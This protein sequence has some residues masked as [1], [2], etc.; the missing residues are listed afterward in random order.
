MGL[1][2][3]FKKTKKIESGYGPKSK[4]KVEINGI[5]IHITDYDGMKN[6]IEL[7]RIQQISL[8][9]ND[10]S[11]WGTDLWWRITSD[12]ATHSFPGGSKGENELLEH[13][14]TSPNFDKDQYHN[15]LKTITTA[16]FIVWKQE[17]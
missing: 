9:T 14:K 2:S 16:E 8:E 7:N 3:M 13:F 1:F 17:I 6:A 12:K 10:S 11:P 5:A 15:A 4:W